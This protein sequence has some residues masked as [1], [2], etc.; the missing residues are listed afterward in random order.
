MTPADRAASRMPGPSS[1]SQTHREASKFRCSAAAT[2]SAPNVEGRSSSASSATRYPRRRIGHGGLGGQV[3]AVVQGAAPHLGDGQVAV[4]GS[5]EQ[6]EHR[7]PFRVRQGIGWARPGGAPTRAGGRHRRWWLARARPNRR[8][9]CLVPTTSV[10][11]G[12]WSS[13]TASTSPRCV[14]FSHD[15]ER[16]PGLGQFGLQ[17]LVLLAQ[18]IGLFAIGTVYGA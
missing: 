14:C 11:S 3:G 1:P 8:H 12:W 10:S 18:S 15:V 13:M 9:A 4:L 2:A 6:L 16:R 17:A 7:I 5:V